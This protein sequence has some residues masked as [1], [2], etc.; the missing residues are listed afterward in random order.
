[1]CGGAGVRAR[2]ARGVYAHTHTQI[3]TY[4]RIFICLS[5]YIQISPKDGDGDGEMKTFL[6]KTRQALTSQTAALVLEAS[7]RERKIKRD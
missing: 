4:I 7:E 6:Q 3:C 1:M 5:V 2:I